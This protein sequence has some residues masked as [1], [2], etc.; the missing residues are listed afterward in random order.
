MTE[1][2]HQMRTHVRL[3]LLAAAG[4]IAAA[5]A[6]VH[7]QDPGPE[8]QSFRTPGWSFTPGITFGTVYDSN[9]AL[10]NAPADTQ[11]TQSDRLYEVEPS[12]ASSTSPRGPSSRPATRDTCGGTPRSIS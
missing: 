8:L 2:R 9:V 5:S 7:A 11:R 6:P 10:A 1:T 3:Y 4:L 12:A